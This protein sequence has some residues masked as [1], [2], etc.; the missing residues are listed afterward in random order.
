MKKFYLPSI[1]FQLYRP[2]RGHSSF[3][4][5]LLSVFCNLVNKYVA[6]KQISNMYLQQSKL[7]T[8]KRNRMT[9]SMH[10][11]TVVL[12]FFIYQLHVPN[13]KVRNK[14]T[15]IELVTWKPKNKSLAVELLTR[16]WNGKSLTIKLVPWSKFYFLT[17]S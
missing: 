4:S 11:E 12:T 16:K 14:N 7:N 9:Q 6:L 10:F 8:K 2:V 5:Q 3:G 13:S 1:V 17:S 15:H